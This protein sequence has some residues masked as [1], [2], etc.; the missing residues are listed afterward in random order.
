MMFCKYSVSSACII[1]ICCFIFAFSILIATMYRTEIVIVEAVLHSDIQMDDCN[2]NNIAFVIGLGAQKAGLSLSQFASLS[3][4]ANSATVSVFR[5]NLNVQ[6]AHHSV[7]CSKKSRITETNWWTAVRVFITKLKGRSKWLFP[8]TPY[9]PQVFEL[10][11]GIL[12]RKRRGWS[13]KLIHF[14]RNSDFVNLRQP[15]AR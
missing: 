8:F 13:H 10:V 12:V 1:V 7:V 11:N 14:A 4:T 9:Q 15:G 6:E 3:G 2:S 5:I